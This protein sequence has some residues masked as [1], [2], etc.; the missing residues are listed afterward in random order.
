MAIHLTRSQKK[1]DCRRCCLQ[2]SCLE[3]AEQR[4]FD[5]L[6]ARRSRLDGIAIFGGRT[7]TFNPKLVREI[8]LGYYFDP[9]HG[10][11]AV[12]SGN[13]FHREPDESSASGAC[14]FERIDVVDRLQWKAGVFSRS[15]A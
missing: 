5:F 11:P 9:R 15:T 14:A 6:A 10:V 8:G 1:L 2:G 7:Q 3:A 13:R 12:R 4:A